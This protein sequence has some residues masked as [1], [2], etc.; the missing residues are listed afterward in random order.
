MQ[1]EYNYGGGIMYIKKVGSLDFF[2]PILENKEKVFE[3]EHVKN[4]GYYPKKENDLIVLFIN[5][6]EELDLSSFESGIL[7]LVNKDGYLAFSL[8]VKLKTKT[9][10]VRVTPKVDGV[11]RD[12][13]TKVVFEVLEMGCIWE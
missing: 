7:K 5:D 8:K 3:L 9:S 11:F 4:V 2:Y 1:G 12:D 10:I 6:E 13:Y